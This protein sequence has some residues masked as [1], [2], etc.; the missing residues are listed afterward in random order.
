MHLNY[1]SFLKY[2]NLL[3]VI[4]RDI[5][6]FDVQNPIISS[7][8]TQIE[9]SKI[10]P[11]D[12]KSLRNDRN[13]ND[14]NDNVGPNLPSPPPP[15]ASGFLLKAPPRYFYNLTPLLPD[16]SSTSDISSPSPFVLMSVNHH[17]QTLYPNKFDNVLRELTQERPEEKMVISDNLH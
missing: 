10:T 7:L 17:L 2:C 12:I 9:S 1:K 4:F 14:D 13:N 5:S 3:E 15:D 16:L 8:L 11:K 6:K